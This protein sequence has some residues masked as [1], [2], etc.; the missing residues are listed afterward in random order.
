MAVLRC[1]T[2]EQ[3][4]LKAFELNELASEL[5]RQGLRERY[6]ELTEEEFRQKYLERIAKCHNRNY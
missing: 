4:L 3:K 2:P 1:M 6:P 5:F